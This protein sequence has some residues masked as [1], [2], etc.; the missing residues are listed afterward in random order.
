[1]RR[2]GVEKTLT[3]VNRAESERDKK[4]AGQYR[5]MKKMPGDE[6]KAVSNLGIDLSC[7]Q[8]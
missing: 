5:V 4:N 2:R 6:K 8:P 3:V 7:H 1:M